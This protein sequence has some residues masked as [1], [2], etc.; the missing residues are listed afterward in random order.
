MFLKNY[1]LHIEYDG[2]EF[3][4]WQVQK[5][6]VTVQGEIEK[7][8]EIL[9]KEKTNLVGSGRTDA[10]VH[11]LGQVANFL[12]PKEIDSKRFLHSL[13]SIIPE[14]IAV[15]NIKIVNEK[16]HSRF[17]A[18]KRSY[19]YLITRT[20]SPF[21]KKYSWFNPV[22]PKADELNRFNK[23]FSGEKDYTSFCRK[24][25]E[26][27]NKICVVDEVRWRDVKDF[28]IFKISAN[29]FLHGMVRT[30]IGTYVEAVKNKLS[31]EELANIFSEKDRTAAAEA[32]PAKGL[33]LY[34]VDY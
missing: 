32:V 9:L 18:K 21:Y 15:K 3:A 12:T 29:R 14:S 30:I 25:S 8:L 27:E 1:K 19:I 28:L 34:K 13:N 23:K 2:T 26:V 10:G 17:D 22:A 6:A 16:F 7:A 20:R 11:A 24:N 5:N 33:F 31:E 4:G